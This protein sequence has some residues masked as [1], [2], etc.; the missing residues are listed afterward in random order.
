MVRRRGILAAGAVAAS[1]TVL[2]R[3]SRRVTAFPPGPDAI[4]PSMARDQAAAL[5]ARGELRRHDLAM[6]FAPAISTSVEPLLHGRRYFPRMLDDIKAATDHVHLL[7]Y[8]Y[9]PGEIGTT[10]LEALAAKVAEGVDVRLAVDATGSE[11]D[12]GSKGAVRATSS[13]RASRS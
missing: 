7:I 11:I 3:R 10:F 1:A 5:L 2:A 4:T 12:T 13:R 8:G 9:K 6:D